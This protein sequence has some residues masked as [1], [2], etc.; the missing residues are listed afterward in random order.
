MIRTPSLHMALI[1]SLQI[2]PLTSLFLEYTLIVHT[3]LSLDAAFAEIKATL[4]ILMQC[5]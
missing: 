4:N 2:Y 5:T 3:D 1:K